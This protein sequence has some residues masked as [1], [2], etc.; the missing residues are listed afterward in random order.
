MKKHQLFRYLYAIVPALFVLILAIAASRLEGIR[1]IFF[2]RDVTTLGNLPFYAGAIS[3]LGIFLWGV[4][5]AICLFTSSLLLKLADRQLLNFF[6]VVA[7]I[8]AYLM[9]DDLFLIHEHSGTWIRGGE[10]SIVLLLGGVVSL[11]LFLFRKIVQNTHYGMLLIAFSMLGASVIADELQP[12][13][14]EK[15]DLHT[16]AE[17][18]TKWVGIV[19]WTGYYV[20]TAFDFIIQKTNEKR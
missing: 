17:D 18:G 13:F 16:L 9:F 19:C 15:G 5:A 3:T 4:T 7:I 10:K 8:S 11:H 2:T 14:W 12:Y 1:L 20:Q 6:L